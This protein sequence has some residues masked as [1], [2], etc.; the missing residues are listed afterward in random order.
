[1]R[2]RFFAKSKNIDINNY[3]TIEALED[4]FTIQF[5]TN[6]IQ[7]CINGDGKWQSL[8]SD[9][10]TVSINRGETLSLKSD[11]TP[12]SNN[13]IGNFTILKKCTFMHLCLHQW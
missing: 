10:D 1:M 11:L 7:Y 3:F 4:E 8:S 12:N 6:S 2:R 5:S 9:T 13:G